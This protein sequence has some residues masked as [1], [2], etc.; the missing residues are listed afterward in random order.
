[1]ATRGGCEIRFRR[2]RIWKPGGQGLELGAKRRQ[3]EAR[4]LPFHAHEEQFG[5]GVLV[6]IGM[7]DI[8]SVLVQ[9]VCHARYQALA[10]RTIDEE[11]G[12]VPHAYFRSLSNW[13]MRWSSSLRSAL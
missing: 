3:V 9:Q 4:Q 12:G 6:L 8:G 1:M 10:V 5:F 13:A 7:G 2:Q 11:N